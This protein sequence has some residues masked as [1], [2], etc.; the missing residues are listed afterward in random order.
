MRSTLKITALLVHALLVGIWVTPT[1]ASEAGARL[2]PGDRIT[3]TVFGQA[4]LSGVFQ[5][6]GSGNIEMP[7]IGATAIGRLTAKEA[8]LLIEKRLAAGY[9]LQPKVTV[10]V[11]E[12]QPI[13]VVGD[14]K[15]AG[16]FPFRPG[17][18]VLSAIAQAG[19]YGGMEAPQNG[20]VADFLLADERLRTLERSRQTLLIRKMRL[21]A[22]RANKKT[23]ELLTSA[24]ETI[25]AQGTDVVAA[26]KE[27]L[28]AQAEALDLEI[29]LLQKQKPRLE[30][31]A[32]AVEKQIE[33]EKRQFELVQTQL[34][35]V[36]KLQSLGLAR[37]TTEVTL[38][39]E[40]ATLDSNISRYRSELARLSVTVGEIDIK[41]QDTQNAHDRRVMT[42]LQDVRARLQDIETALPIVRE[43]REVRLQLT[44][45]SLDVG[46]NQPSH[47]IIITRMSNNQPKMLDVNEDSLLEP[48]DIVT[49]RRLRR[50]SI[51]GASSL[52]GPSTMWA[53]HP[54]N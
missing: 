35:D 20:A 43:V 44:G 48:G 6:D 32:A 10:R 3:V 31:A 24:A 16:T 42:E 30:S 15:T 9:I 33:A 1:L 21:E 2:T 28:R 47:R 14:V 53:R 29:A 54:A 17:S 34:N 41:L 38:Q 7:L 40:H 46:E 11:S 37:R 27:L 22:Q 51:D 4:D 18:L 12:L 36:A 19:G 26:E 5:L 50:R 8:G 25:D 23:F 49:V 52:L 45:N 39:R 13:Y